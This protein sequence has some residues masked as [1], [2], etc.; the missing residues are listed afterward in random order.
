LLHCTRDLLDR[1]AAFP[2]PKRVR[3]YPSGL[4]LGQEWSERTYVQRRALSYRRW[5]LTYAGYQRTQDFDIGEQF[6]NYMLHALEQVYCEVEIPDGLLK[7]LKAEGLEVTR[8]M[9]WGRLVFRLQSTPYLALRML[10]RALESA[11]GDNDDQSN[12]FSWS[13]VELNL[14]GAPWYNPAKPRVT[15]LH[16]DGSPATNL[17]LY[18]DNGRIMGS[19]EE[20]CRHGVRQA[21]LRLQYLGNQDA[22]RKQRGISQCPGAWARRIIY[23]SQGVTRKMLSQEKWDRAKEFLG[24][25]HQGVA[26]PQALERN[27]FRSDKGFLVHVAQ[28]YDFVQPYLKG[29]HLSEEVWRG[30]RGSNGWKLPDGHMDVVEEDTALDGNVLN[31]AHTYAPAWVTPVPRLRDDVEAW[32]KFFPLK[33]VHPIRGACYVA[34]GAADASGEGFG[35]NLHPLGMGPLLRQGFWCMDASEQSSNWHELLT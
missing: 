4:G 1:R 17:I 19:T 21:T 7:N 22:V 8:Q 24:W 6:H 3:R 29:F 16:R 31:K 12:A 20:R 30:N 11:L 27:H 15:K 32:L 9:R 14:L 5:E 28:R 33:I 2:G 23:T 13:G 34:Y 35:S 25:V 10:T 18:F 26:H